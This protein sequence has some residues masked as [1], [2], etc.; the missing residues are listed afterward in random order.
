MKG[1]PVVLATALL[2]SLGAYGQTIT[3][4]N[5]RGDG[6]AAM[7][8]V[9]VTFENQGYE[10]ATEKLGKSPVAA[11]S[12]IA[13]CYQ[14]IR[15][16]IEGHNMAADHAPSAKQFCIPDGVNHIQLA[17]IIVRAS[18]EYPEIAHLPRETVVEAALKQAFPC[19]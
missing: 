12:D 5:D 8:R 3:S 18:D 9:A 13:G 4:S 14:Y 2:C 6:F 16:F 7:C 1:Q 19:D 15:G 10:A 11:A 17:R